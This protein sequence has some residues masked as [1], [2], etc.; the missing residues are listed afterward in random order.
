M[1]AEAPVTRASDLT[2]SLR[3]LRQVTMLSSIFSLQT[4][5]VESLLLDGTSRFEVRSSHLPSRFSTGVEPSAPRLSST[6]RA[7]AR[8]ER[9]H[10]PADDAAPC[11]LGLLPRPRLPRPPLQRPR[12]ATRQGPLQRH[13]HSALPT[14]CSFPRRAA[15]SE[16]TACAAQDHLLLDPDDATPV[17][18]LALRRPIAVTP[19]TS[20]FDALNLFQTGRSHMALVSD[21]APLLEQCWRE[22][23]E[24]P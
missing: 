12:P 18:Q 6:G 7:H 3:A 22:D 23:A 15:D 13:A 14:P 16:H 21:D 11:P 1:D 17:R 20:I 5:T 2:S 9:G 10:G 19:A 4:K 24:V 8:R